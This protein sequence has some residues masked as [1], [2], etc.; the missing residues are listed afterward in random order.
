VRESKI[1][2]HQI[3]PCCGAR[4]SQSLKCSACGRE[5]GREE[6]KKGWDLGG[7]KFVV[8]EQGEVEAVRLKTVKSIAVEGFVPAYSFDPIQFNQSYYVVPAEGAEKAYN[9]MAEALGLMELYALARITAHG[10]EHVAVI[11]AR[12]RN[13]ILTTLWYPDEVLTP[14]EIPQTAISERE[15]ELA[16]QLLESY[17]TEADLSKYENRYVSALRE[18]IN[19]KMLGQPVP[20]QKAE[21]AP[22]MD[23]AQALVA[24]VQ[25]KRRAEA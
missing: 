24:S 8:L 10:K 11:R 18:L 12:G 23:L 22:E 5:V 13:L 21:V 25:R 4:V 16:K 15:R 6:V 1:S 20:E 14:P 9:L 19:A 17:K 7:G 2:F 3:S